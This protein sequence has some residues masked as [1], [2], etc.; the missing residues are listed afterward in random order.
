MSQ[1][2]L[3]PKDPSHTILVGWDIPT[4]SY[5]ATVLAQEEDNEEVAI[6]SMG[7]TEVI[8]QPKLLSIALEEGGYSEAI[9]SETM[10]SLW[11]DRDGVAF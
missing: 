4:K 11:A 6:F 8:S 2:T 1:Y 10:Y 5:F 9:P 7:V 3:P